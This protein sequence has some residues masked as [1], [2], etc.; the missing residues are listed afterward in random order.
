MRVILH[1]YFSLVL[2]RLVPKN[3]TLLAGCLKAYEQLTP[4]AFHEKIE[5]VIGKCRASGKIEMV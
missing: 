4:L 1:T 5:Q 2:G 3:L